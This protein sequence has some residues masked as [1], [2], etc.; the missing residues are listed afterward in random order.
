MSDLEIFKKET[1]D[2]LWRIKDTMLRLSG[3][4]GGN[5]AETAWKVEVE[6]NNIIEMIETMRGDDTAIVL[7][8]QCNREL[9]PHKLE[10]GR[11]YF[12]HK[13]KT[14]YKLPTNPYEWE[15]RNPDLKEG[16]K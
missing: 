5:V 9:C 15:R 13:C 2:R 7:C 11:H 12:C 3:Y 4:R 16:T 8:P 14:Y 10:S 6:L 1:A